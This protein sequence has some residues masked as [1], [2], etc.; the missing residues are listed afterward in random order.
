MFAATR[1][2]ARADQPEG[3]AS[4]AEDAAFA[5]VDKA[6][7][8]GAVF[9]SD[10]LWYDSKNKETKVYLAALKKYAKGGKP[11]SFSGTTF[12]TTMTLKTIADQ[13][14]A[15]LTP[16]AVLAALQ[17]AA[18]IHVFGAIAYAFV[19]VRFASWATGWL[20][21]A[22][23]FTGIAGAC[24]NVAYGFNTIHVS[25]GAVDLVDQQHR[26][27]VATDCRRTDRT[28]A[29]CPHNRPRRRCSP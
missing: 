20:A 21:A 9:N 17:N 16:A 24:G 1:T 6:V 7:S 14:G 28:D 4:C 18:G 26:R 2:P 11:S 12:A 3:R 8:E 5:K 13:L 15:N 10:T 27:N 19:L 25:L 22:T 29:S 23:L